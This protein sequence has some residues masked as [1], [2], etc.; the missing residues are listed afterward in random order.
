MIVKKKI[1]S[2]EIIDKKNKIHI[3]PKDRHLFLKDFKVKTGKSFFYY[4]RDATILNDGKI[5]TFNYDIISDYLGLKSL[6]KFILIKKLILL[7]SYIFSILFKKIF[8]K[9]VNITKNCI[10]IH[11]RN[12]N[13]Y[14]HWVADTLP[15]IIYIKTIYKNSYVILPE[16][17]KIKFI[18]SSLELYLS[19]YV[20]RL[21]INSLLLARV[22]FA[23]VLP[24]RFLI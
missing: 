6:S 16:E 12:S 3:H 14:F 21:A 5:F 18:I 22:A 19:I 11:N 24:L 13:G 15:K 23:Y 9:N 2:N 8:I 10:L 20:L 4:F 7:T 1:L 17:L